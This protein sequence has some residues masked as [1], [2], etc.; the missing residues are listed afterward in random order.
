MC[1]YFYHVGDIF[2]L[3]VR[4]SQCVSSDQLSQVSLSSPGAGDQALSLGNTLLTP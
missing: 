2:V 3:P 4:V 1:H